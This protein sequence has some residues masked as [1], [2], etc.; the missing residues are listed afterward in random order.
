[1]VSSK[2]SYTLIEVVDLQYVPV[3]LS[4]AITYTPPTDSDFKG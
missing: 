4:V 1:M 3:C 2:I